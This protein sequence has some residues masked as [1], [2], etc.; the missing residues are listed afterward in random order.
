MKREPDPVEALPPTDNGV[1]PSNSSIEGFGPDDV[2]LFG[3][4]K[5]FRLYEKLGAHLETR[6]GRAGATFTVWAPGARRVSVVGGFNRWRTRAG[7]LAPIVDSGLWT[8][9]FEGATPGSLYKY[10][11]ESQV[12]NHAENKADP[13]AFRSQEPPDRASVVWDLDY[14]WGDEAWMSARVSAVHAKR[15][16][17]IYEL[18]VGSWRRPAGD[19]ESFLNYRDLTETLIPYLLR[20]GFS[21]V[22]LLPV[23]EHPYYPS[24]GYQTTG[25]FA[26]TARY[27]TPQDLMYLIDRLHQSGIGVILDWVPSHFPNDAHGLAFFD[28]TFLFE[29][30][31]PRLGFHPDWKSAIFNYGR[32]QVRSFL[33]SSALFWLDRYHADGL[34][35]DGVASML[36]LDYSRKAG[37]WIPNRFGGRENL[38]AIE[39]L[40]GLNA[41]V[42]EHHPGAVTIAEESTAWPMVSRPTHIGGLGFDMKWDMGWMHDSLHYMSLDPIHRKFHHGAATFRMVYAFSENFV[43]AFSHDEVV[44]G[45]RSLLDKMPGDTWQKFANLRALFG[46][47]WGHPGKK[48]LFMGGESGQW[49]E[50][51]HERELDWSLADEPVH[52]GL[53]LWVADLNR[54][55]RDKRALHE[56]D[57]D[58]QGFSWIDCADADQSVLVFLRRSDPPEQSLILIAN[59][60][61]LPRHDYR[62]GVPLSGSWRELL[63]SDAECYGGSGLG[64]YGEKA[65]ESLGYHGQ[66]SSLCLT[67][68]PLAVL[69]LEHDPT[70]VVPAPAAGTEPAA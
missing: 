49:R 67:L 1:G 68:P 15:P 41:A 62:I 24:W 70:I 69:F 6:D 55:Y 5:H 8:G 54:L 50:W 60:T 32:P 53:A 26:A 31:D 46:L 20:M 47:M 13:F 36:Y 51:S 27:G 14:A 44:H 43:L 40:R 23:M 16:M 22:Q 2:H 10:R 21:H 64:N 33:T 30:A 9:W 52:R 35:V 42:H 59:L 25:Y 38:D 37:E 58:S 4:G 3:E 56:R 18:H 61:S 63:N 65:T 17:S 28:G 29:H 39:F 48:L 57:F 34:R 66:P 11:I 45:K 19:P 12:K 7:A